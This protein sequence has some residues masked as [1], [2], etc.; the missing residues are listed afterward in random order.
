MQRV[1]SGYTIIEVMIFL[2][3]SAALLGSAINL[4]TGR[5]NQVEFDQRMRDVQSKMQDWINDVSTGFT[6]GDPSQQNCTLNGTTP[7]VKAGGSSN[8]PECVF[9][10]KAIQFT[11]NTV[12]PDYSEHIYTYSVFGTR[13][14][15]SNELATNL[16]ESNPEPAVGQGGPPVL[17]LTEVFNLSPAHV[18]SVK[19]VTAN[20]PN[21]NSTSHLVGFFNSFNTE[22]NTSQNGATDINSYLFRFDGSSPTPADLSGGSNIRLCME[23]KSLCKV[24]S[25]FD[26]SSWPE[27]LSS[28]LVCLSDG[29]HTSQLTISSAAGTGASVKLDYVACS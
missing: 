12:N 16:V 13:L 24:Q 15:T 28:M 26:N 14:T 4:I 1:S 20:T 8:D 2:A 3:I 21:T 23:L 6:G 10:G 18:V 5:Q 7:V 11:D 27:R 9:L 29:K 25:G 17:D 19:T 22:Q